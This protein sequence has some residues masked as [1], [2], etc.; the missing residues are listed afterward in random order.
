MFLNKFLDSSRPYEIVSH[1][2]WESSNEKKIIKLDWNE[3]SFG[4]SPKV[5]KALLEFIQSGPMHWYPDY[6]NKDLMT[7]LS[8]YSL[9]QSQNLEYFASS[10]A[11]HETILRACC[12]HGEKLVIL[13]PTYDNFRATAETF[14]LDIT[15][16]DLI[17][18]FDFEETKFFD[19]L[20]SLTPRLV[21]ICNPNNPTG[22]HISLDFLSDLFLKFDRT[23]FI[24]DE[25]YYEYSKKSV[26]S[27]ITS[28]NNI[29]ITRS[30]SKAFGLASF[31]IGYALANEGI[32]NSLKSIKNPKSITSLS[33]I[34]A[35]SALDDIDYLE[36]VVQSTLQNKD[37][38]IS[39][40]KEKF[41]ED[42]KVFF[43]QGNYVLMKPLNFEM[44][45]IK[46][47][48]EEWGIYLRF[49]SDRGELNQFFRATIGTQEE[50]ELVLKCFAAFKESAV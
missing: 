43:G 39:E 16:Y 41:A 28:R 37:F 11:L 12:N 35:V 24:I 2:A 17:E 32:I 13:G 20:K 46:V 7:S 3:S 45:K 49:F 6:Q 34:A 50:M 1:R 47:F 22:T 19:F 21:Y 25:A 40:L 29:I 10:D 33:Q 4:P 15:H 42:F 48:L 26:S 18:P 30:F 8:D 44:Q 5:A 31:R 14:G 23:L 36:K 9:V 27:L 38:F